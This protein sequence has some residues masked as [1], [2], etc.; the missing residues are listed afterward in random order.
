MGDSKWTDHAQYGDASSLISSLCDSQIVAL[1][2]HD[3]HHTVMF[4][5]V[6]GILVR[7]YSYMDDVVHI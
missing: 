2:V 1:H 3:Q 6:K 5:H 4:S 7:R